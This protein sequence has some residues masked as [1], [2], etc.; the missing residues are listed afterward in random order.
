MSTKF[1]YKTSDD[2]REDFLRSISNALQTIAGISNPNVSYGTDHYIIGDAIGKIAELA[3]YNGIV[4]ADAQ[5]ADTATGVDLYRIASVYGLS[6]RPAGGSAGYLVLSASNAVGLISGLQLIDPSGL[7]YQVSVGGTYNPGDSVPITSIDTGTAVNVAAGVI[8]RWVS[9]P[10]Y[11]DPKSPVGVGGL[12]GGANA[13]SDE[14]LRDR[15]LSVLRSPPGGGNW[16]QLASSAETSSSSVQK[17]FVYPAYNGPSTVLVAVA[18]VPSSTNKNRNVNSLVVSG[19]IKPAIQSIIFEGVELRTTTVQNYPASVSIGLS[20]PS[21]KTA[22][23]PGP[24]GGWLD[25]NPFPYS[26]ANA[27]NITSAVYS[28]ASTTSFKV[29]SDLAPSAG[30][31]H[32]VYVDSNWNTY[33]AKVLSYNPSPT[34]VGGFNVWDIVVDTPL[35]GITTGSWIFPDALNM[36][37]YISSLL[38][39]FA[40]LGPGQL[41]TNSNLL[42]YAYRRPYVADSWSTDLDTSVLKFL[43]NIGDEVRYVNYLYKSVNSPP[44]PSDVTQGPYILVPSQ[45]AFY[46]I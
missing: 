29:F 36:N 2:Y 28:V 39:V 10:A 5:M 19:T 17:A 35:I 25:G 9:P 37:S 32:I 26:T 16:A 12:T 3:A 20:L 40:S 30:V 45:I 21:A 31:S 38:S 27:P 18:G 33:H 6:L 44:T 41:T 46:P 22:S 13:E 4:A 42:P 43:L 1:K 34:V 14:G 7:K 23:P 11:V 8:L 15:L 24:G